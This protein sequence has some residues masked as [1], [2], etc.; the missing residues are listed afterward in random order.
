[1]LESADEEIRIYAARI[2]TGLARQ[3]ENKPDI[4]KYLELGIEFSSKSDNAETRAAHNSLQ[5]DYSLLVTGDSAQAVQYKKAAMAEGWTE[6]S[7]ELNSFAWWCYENSVNLEEAETLA[8][9][10][11][12]LSQ[13][14]RAKA[15]ILDTVAHILKARGN[16]EEAIKFMEMAAAEDPEDE[17]WQETLD[18]F[19]KE[20]EQKN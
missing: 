7:G 12:E 2:M 6:D 16:L 18:N 4:K 15:M 1:V 10:A 20:L 17:Q 13:P 19:K 9:K 3:N 11:V 8:R 14:G 5:A